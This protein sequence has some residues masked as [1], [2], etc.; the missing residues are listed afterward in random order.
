MY[1]AAELEAVVIYDSVLFNRTGQVRRWADS[2]E[3]NFTNAA[4]AAAPARSGELVAG[5]HGYVERI[6]PR[7]LQTIVMS[8]APHSLY[9]LAGTTGPITSTRLTNAKGTGPAM[10]RLKPGGGYPALFREAVAGQEANNFFAV[11]ARATAR[12]HPSLAGWDPDFG[13]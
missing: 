8:E 1:Y 7:H 11:A 12:R 9:V 10:L 2:L 5:I 3:R 13:Y 6:G 4:R